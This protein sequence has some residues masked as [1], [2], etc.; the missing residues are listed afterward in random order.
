MASDKTTIRLTQRRPRAYRRLGGGEDGDG[1][2]LRAAGNIA[3]QHQRRAELAQRARKGQ[4]RSSKN[5]G[6]G[7]RQQH[8][9]KDDTLRC[10]QRAR[11][12]EKSGIDLLE[13]AQRG[14]VHQR[15][16]HD[17]RGNHRCRPGEDD[18]DANLFQRLADEAAPSKSTSRK[19]PTTVGGSTRGSVRR[20]SIQARRLPR[21][22]YI[23]RAATGPA[24]TW[25][26]WPRRWWPARYT[27]AIDRWAE[28]RCCYCKS[29]LHERWL[30]RREL[31]RKS[32]NLRAACFAAA[33]LRT[34]RPDRR[35]DRG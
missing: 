28:S 22:P 6:R 5:S 1:H 30:A 27:A 16:S 31:S 8:S 13:C 24:K 7:Q 12:I 17:G 18:G 10:A 35:W 19:K 4:H 2:G 3:G 15:K 14:A 20:P 11:C 29:M 23:S 9:A 32:T 33:A 25:R 21:M 34:L 26:R